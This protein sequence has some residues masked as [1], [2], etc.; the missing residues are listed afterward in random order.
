MRK[1]CAKMVSRL[2]NDEQKECRVQI[3][4][5]ILKELETEPDMLSRVVTGDESW[6][7]EYNP[8]TKRQSLELKSASSPRKQESKE[9]G[10]SFQKSR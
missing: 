3:C 2:L 7:F 10:C 4:Q 5:N 8:F 6:I 1:I 9:G